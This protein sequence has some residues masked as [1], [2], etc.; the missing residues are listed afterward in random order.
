[1]NSIARWSERFRLL[2]LTV[3]A[4]VVALGV[5][6]LPGVTVEAVPEFDPPHV[7]IQTEA[8]GLS[9]EEVE[10][11]ITAP[12]EVDIL[13]G[14]AFLDEMR[15]ESVAGLSSIELIFEPGTDLNKARQLVAERL[16]LTGDL[17]NVSAPS[18]LMQPL[19]STSRVM[20][21]RLSSTEV[22]LID[23]SVLARW[24]VKPR[25]MG[26]PGVANVAI[27]G[28]REQQM[29][30]LV[31]P[32]QLAGRGVTLN[33]VIQTTG[34]AVWVSPLTYLRASTPGSGGFIETG[35]QRLGVQHVLPITTPAD[36]SQMS[37]EGANGLTLRDIATVVEDHQP[38]IGDAAG[39]GDPGLVLVVEKF[40]DT[41]TAEVTAAL[42]SALD[43]MRPG[44]AGVTVDSTVYRPA[45]F[46]E[47]AAQSLGLG[48]LLSVIL[49]ALLIGLGFRS[50]RLGLLALAVLV[51]TTTGAVLVLTLLGVGMNTMIFAGLVLALAVIVGDTIGDLHALRGFKASGRRTGVDVDVA[52]QEAG[53]LA[54]MLRAS[55]YA[56]FFGGLVAVL[57]LVPA[58][59]LPEV[60]GAFLRPLV[61][62]FAVT[63]AVAMILAWTL[64][65]ALVSTLLT[66]TAH[67]PEPGSIARVRRGYAAALGRTASRATA[68]LV[69]G[70]LLAAGAVALAPLLAGAARGV[71]V[72][73]DSSLLVRM[74]G[75]PGT[76]IDEMNRVTQ[77]AGALIGELPGVTSVDGHIGRAIAGDQVV[78]I[79]SSELWVNLADGA[80]SR[81]LAGDVEGI[82]QSIPG[83]DAEVVGYAEAKVGEATA[84]REAEFAVRVF[85]I[86][87][88]VLRQ[89]AERV[90][91]LVGGADGVTSVAL[92]IPEAEPVTEIEVDLAAAERA[93]LKPG[94]VRRAAATLIQGLEVGYLFEQQKVFQVVVRGMPEVRHSLT[95]LENLSID[96]PAGGQVRLGDVA[97][98]RIAPRNTVLRHVDTERYIDVVA[99]V[100]GRS[101]GDVAADVQSAVRG[102]EFEREYHAEVPA[103]FID[104]RDDG[105]ITAG[106]IAAIVL[107]LLVLVQTA[108]RSWPLAAVITLA[109]PI[110]LLGGVAA[111]L[112]VGGP[113]LVTLTGLAAVLAITVRD[114]VLLVLA[115]REHQRSG[116]E[117]RV[118]GVLAG[119]RERLLPTLLS[120]AVAGLALVPLVALGGALGRELLLPLAAVVW[121]GL[122]T[123]WLLTLVI[124][125]IAL[126]R[127]RVPAGDG[128]FGDDEIAPAREGIA[129]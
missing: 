79:N 22:P 6:L 117:G 29:Q 12:M 9:A 54:R 14:I 120:G 86:E 33:Q 84:G 110:A 122:L 36:L 98:I 74:A 50:W 83:L 76:G 26:V 102:M 42:E 55:R 125:P 59:F 88:D 60:E 13:A 90:A 5:A 87:L 16:P 15:S 126:F 121:G 47:S 44:L 1:M 78:G 52:D 82:V 10:Q 43:D 41:S 75:A 124:L 104:Q 123:S 103:R 80:D 69:V 24:N 58:V 39:G 4:G 73:N 105:L 37:V 23:L 38:L 51:V 7:E 46:I 108:V 31:D 68:V 71:P 18:V 111:A 118:D 116:Q 19:S 20:M 3:A 109:L 72:V 25:L 49:V 107:G 63:L 27:W 2:V 101:V 96:T 45:T 32:A 8:L 85:G 17:P 89:E 113:T 95:S 11:L 57:V 94:D 92:D 53:R 81:G 91:D 28:H 112:L 40:P 34:N 93:A 30:V 61:L 48:S 56:A 67:R 127:V 129:S 100:D 62:A 114:S 65:V 66:R 115:V 97:D 35:N 119:A 77:R 21:I 64:T 128:T 106:L 99:S 70:A